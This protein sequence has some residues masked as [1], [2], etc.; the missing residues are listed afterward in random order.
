MA[1]DADRDEVAPGVATIQLINAALVSGVLLFLGI[2][3]FLRLR[4]PDGAFG[5]PLPG[6]NRF[7][8]GFAAVLAVG[9]AMAASW[10]PRTI[11]QGQRR[12]LAEGRW[13][14]GRPSGRGVPA[15]TTDAGRLLSVYTTARIVQL[16]LLEGAAFLCLI[17]YYLRGDPLM[18]ALALGLVGA[19]LVGWPTRSRL[20][21]W[22][23]EQA[24]YLNQERPSLPR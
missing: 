1:T 2:S 19:M 8:P 23:G 11:V 16:A 3:L 9:N 21:A 18:L 24:E 7:L 6:T 5:P 12:A 13:T 20:D 17:V 15:A 22:L 14:G 10:I 4:H